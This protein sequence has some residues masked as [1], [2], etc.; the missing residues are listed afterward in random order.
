MHGSVRDNKRPDSFIPFPPSANFLPVSNRARLL[1]ARFA[2]LSA[3][4]E[5]S[6]SGPFAPLMASTWNAELVYRMAAAFGQESLQHGINGWYSPAINLH[7]SAFSGR[8]FEYYSEDPL[9]S[10]KLAAA[11]VSG[12]GDQGMYCYLKHFALNET[13][14]GRSQLICTWA[15]EQTMRELYLRPFEIAFREAR[16]T[17][18]YSAE[19]G[20]MASKVMRAGNAVMASQTCL[21]TQLGHTNRALL[22]DLLRG[23]WGFEG[24]VISDYWTWNGDNHRDLAMRNGC[25]TYLNMPMSFL[26]SISDYDSATSRTAMRQAIHNTAYTV[27][28]SN[29]MQGVV[30]G[31]TVRVNPASWQYV[32]WAITAVAALLI[33]NAIRMIVKRGHDELAHPELYKRGKRAEAKLQKKLAKLGA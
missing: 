26:W 16:M 11:A 32:I 8:V 31:G 17:V 19:D 18:N 13:D 21:G 29:A 9:L 27:V 22:T 14:T 24:M 12:A 15:D 3:Q 28:N 5:T 30:P 4:A 6:A 10:G 25:D 1:R 2:F 23:E 33:A 7:R 20:S